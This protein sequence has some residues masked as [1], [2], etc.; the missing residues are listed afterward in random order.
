MQFQTTLAKSTLYPLQRKPCLLVALAVNQPI[1]SVAAE[2][3]AAQIVSDPTIEG[4]VQEQIS[5]NGTD[6]AEAPPVFLDTDERRI[7]CPRR[8]GAWFGQGA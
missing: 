3:H 4:I 6:D 5:Q 1:V 2:P 8:L 7:R